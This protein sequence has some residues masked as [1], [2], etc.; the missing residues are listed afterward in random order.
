MPSWTPCAPAATATEHLLVV[1]TSAALAA[2]VGEPAPSRL[3]ERMV[4]GGELSAPHL[5]DV[6]LLHALRRLVRQ[7]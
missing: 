5:I 7:G 4:E 6:E 2:L 3:I 1:D